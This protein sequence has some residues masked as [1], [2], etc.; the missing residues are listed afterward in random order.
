MGSDRIKAKSDYMS[1]GRLRPAKYKKEGIEMPKFS[2]RIPIGPEE[3]EISKDGRLLSRDKI[4]WF[5]PEDFRILQLWDDEAEIEFR[6]MPASC[7]WYRNFDVEYLPECAWEGDESRR[8]VIG[9]DFPDPL[10]C[11]HCQLYG[12]APVEPEW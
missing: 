12:D 2:V 9:E 10:D 1:V 6:C 11:L 4:Y 5:E 7:P 3:F 8:S